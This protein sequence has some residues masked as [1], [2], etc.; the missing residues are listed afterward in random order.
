[1]ALVLVVEDEPEI[2]EILES[3]L[4]RDGYRTERAGDGKTALNLYRAAQ[5][6]LVLLDLM[7]PE[8]DGLEV[9]RRIR[10]E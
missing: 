3:Y 2:A 7:L 4:R 10:S 9:L 5:P 6:D 8:L 1:M